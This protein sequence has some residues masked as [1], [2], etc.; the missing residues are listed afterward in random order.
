M[1]IGSYRFN[2]S[3]FAGSLGDLGTLIPLSIG[4]V[5]INGLSFSS[6]FLWVGLFYL[7]SGVYY[8][9]PIPVQP[10]KLVSAIAIAFPEKISL[11]VISATGLLFGGA[12]IL[13]AFTGL[14]D[15]LA[16]LSPSR[17]FAVSSLAWVS[18]S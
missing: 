15:W 7:L 8:N 5:T 9:L 1:Q 18:S 13:L 14:I 16:R 11:P 12:L 3:E 2:R 17:L 4:L 6:V 10:L